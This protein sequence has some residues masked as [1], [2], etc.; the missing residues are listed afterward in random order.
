[1]SMTVQVFAVE[2]TKSYDRIDNNKLA[3]IDFTYVSNSFADDS[4]EDVK[5]F[6]NKYYQ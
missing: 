1:M 5:V 4:S 6:N 3:S 2:K